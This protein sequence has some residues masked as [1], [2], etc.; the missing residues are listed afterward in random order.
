MVVSN[1]ILFIPFEEYALYPSFIPFLLRIQHLATNIVVVAH[2]ERR[3]VKPRN[4]QETKR[5]VERPATPHTITMN[6]NN[7]NKDKIGKIGANGE[8]N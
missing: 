1:A 7:S 6:I 5:K 8:A 3:V 4:E 2:K